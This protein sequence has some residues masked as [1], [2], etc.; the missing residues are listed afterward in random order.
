MKATAT[1]KATVRHQA[2]ATNTRLSWCLRAG[3]A[4]QLGMWWCLQ[5]DSSHLPQPRAVART[6]PTLQV[7]D[8]ASQV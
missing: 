2:A 5:R 8:M 6:C 1:A 7:R 4:L 3:A